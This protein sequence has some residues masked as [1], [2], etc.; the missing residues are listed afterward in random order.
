MLDPVQQS[1]A[2]Q[3]AAYLAEQLPP[4]WRRLYEGLIAEGFNDVQAMSLLNTWVMGMCLR[5][6]H[7]Q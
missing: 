5:S 3:A 7:A 4:M 6:N 2:D 1:Q